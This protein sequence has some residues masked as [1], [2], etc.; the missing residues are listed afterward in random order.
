MFFMAYYKN[1]EKTAEV[2]MPDG[3]LRTGDLGAIDD[4]G[5]VYITGRK[6]DIIITAGGKNVSPIPMEQEIAKCPIVEHA[7]V[8][9]DNRPF[10]GALVTLDPEGL[11]A[12]L[13]SVGLSADTQLDRVA[14]TAAVHDEIRSMWTRRTRRFRAPNPCVS[15]WCW[16]RSSPES[17]C[18]TPSLKVVRPAVN[19]VFADVIDQQLYA[20]KR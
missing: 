18:L 10:I 4:D 8:V 14:A 5:F 1:P 17:N 19:R 9:G 3:W 15:S 13:P 12:W 11:A 2:K 20:G 6:K 16:M 7:V